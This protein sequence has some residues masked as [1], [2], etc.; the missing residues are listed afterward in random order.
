MRDEALLKKAALY[1]VAAA[2]GVKV[3]TV[4]W[5]MIEDIV[6]MMF[7]A[8]FISFAMEPA[9][10]WFERRGARR[11]LG[12]ITV[13]LGVVFFVGGIVAAA[14]AVIVSQAGDL[15]DALPRLITDAVWQVNDIA[16][17]NFDAARLL[18]D[19]GLTD[20]IVEAVQRGA[21]DLGVGVLQNAGNLLTILFLTFYLSADADRIVKSVCSLVKPHRQREVLDTVK[22]LREKTGNYLASRAVLAAMSGVFH[23]VCF[24]A[25]GVPYSLPLGLWVGVVSQIIPVVGTYLAAALPVV[26]ALGAEGGVKKTLFVLVA[27][28]L[29]QQLE[30]NLLSPKVTRAKMSLHPIVGLLSVII[31][32]RVAGVAGALFAIPAA[33]STASVLDVYVK[34][35]GTPELVSENSQESLDS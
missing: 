24:W 33:A 20:Q 27:V 7:S 14:G 5:H 30:N 34:R 10:S 9:V 3:I 29:Y 15:A 31:G 21:A 26:V 6:V 18:R 19:G 32:S 11:G 23:A 28:T 12:A 25:L 35:H 8:L 4:G 1:L 17:T 16:G 13:L 2:V 22:T